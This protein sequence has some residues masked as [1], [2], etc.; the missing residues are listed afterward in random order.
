MKKLIIILFLT[1]TLICFSQTL[2]IN[3]SENHFKIDQTRLL[4]LSHIENIENYNDLSNYSEIIISFNQSKYSFISI[5]NSLEYTSSY[6]VSGSSSA[7]PFKLY[8]TSLPI[9]SIKTTNRIV[10][11]PKVSANFTYS[12]DKQ[13]L[14]SIIGIEL[15]GGFTRGYP[16]KTYDLEFWEDEKGENTRDVQFGNLREDDD[17][18]LDGLYNEPIR[19]RSFISHKL[20]L[21]LHSLYYQDD[22]PN[23]KAGADVKYAEMFLNGRYN[24]I[25]NLSEQVDRKQLK[26]KKFKKGNIKGELYKGDSWGGRFVR[27]RVI[28]GSPIVFSKLIPFNNNSRFWGG[29]QMRY[30]KS[31]DTT[32]WQNLYNFV[33]FVIN[34]KD[35]EFI[36]NIWSKF[37]YD[38]Y[39]D[40]FIFLNLLKATDNTGKNIYLAK[41]KVDEPY[42]YVP[43]DLD[44]VF[45]REW[46]GRKETYVGILTN[47]FHRRVIK[48]NPNNYLG[49]ISEKWVGYRK[50]ILNKD[51][52]FEAIRNQY[53]FL[54]ENKIY[55]REA[56]VYRNY[57]FNQ[58]ELSYMLD[59][60]EKRLSL[61]D[62]YFAPS[63][64]LTVETPVLEAPLS[65][66]FNK[67][68]REIIVN[69][70]HSVYL[71]SVEIFNILGVKVSQWST[72]N[73]TS[74]KLAFR[75]GNLAS[76]VYII[77][78]KTDKEEFS[79]K[80]IIQ[81]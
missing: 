66:F 34:S 72:V 27:G 71:K 58:K 25:Y 79:K 45:G 1:N 48:L 73:N 61:L 53:Q 16:K 36:D 43:W 22:E 51:T 65:V 69:K 4:I 60:I 46:R 78:I 31:E 80:T 52:I 32:N 9:I 70:P 77:R 55:E 21:R 35:S 67:N 3:I 23:A 20:W 37:N 49:T 18:I 13:V 50:T 74:N 63:A 5:P 41:Y 68:T 24:G 11:E 39:L 19:L 81:N 64:N 38:N 8:F 47:G 2:N 6:K 44:G 15:R 75:A 17:L 26:L 42:Y 54:S 12:D 76:G 28:G 7:N 30:P 33:N 10:N 62:V 14:T 29:Y 56:I 59:W 57:N 40:Y